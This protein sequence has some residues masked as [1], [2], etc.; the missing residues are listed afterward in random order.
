M[1]SAVQV[2]VSAVQVKVKA[3]KLHKAA[4]QMTDGLSNNHGM[5]QACV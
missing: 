1:V 2:K 3:A 5:T 4:T